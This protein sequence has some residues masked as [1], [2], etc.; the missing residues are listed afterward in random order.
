[1]TKE[2]YDLWRSLPETQ[3]VLGKVQAQITD[4][5]Q[6]LSNGGTVNKDST[7]ATAMNTA[8]KVGEIRGLAFI[9]GDLSED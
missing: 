5:A 8:D 1:V 2:Q 3:E 9:L 7:S 6:H 4:L